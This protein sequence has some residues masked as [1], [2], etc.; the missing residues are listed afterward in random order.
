MERGEGARGNHWCQFL[1]VD[2]EAAETKIE[3]VHEQFLY[4]VRL[5]VQMQ[6]EEV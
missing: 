6:V 1:P 2:G 4:A 3:A 5:F